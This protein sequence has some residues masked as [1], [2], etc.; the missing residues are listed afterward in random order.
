MTNTGKMLVVGLLVV[1]L[2]VAGYLLFPKDERQS[3]V[4]GTVIGSPTTAAEGDSRTSETPVVV[5][6]SV[7]RETPPVGQ[8][9]EFAATPASPATT[10]SPAATATTAMAVAPAMPAT[11]A[12][13]AMPAMP[14]VP[15]TPVAPDT[16]QAARHAPN[17]SQSATGAVASAGVQRSAP[18]RSRPVLHAEQMRGQR[19]NDQQRSGSNPLSEALTEELVRESAKPDPSLPLPPN[20]DSVNLSG[21]GPTG[22][23]SNPVAS[24]MTDQLVRESSK[25]NTPSS[26]PGQSNQH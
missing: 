13:P 14:T 4:T 1:N 3:A 18:P 17:G 10:P 24:S 25:V 22:R 6:G 5:A 19:H 8:A 11:P 7:V 12:M 16:G 20:S 21:S 2:G 9:D 26:W 23:G 15:R